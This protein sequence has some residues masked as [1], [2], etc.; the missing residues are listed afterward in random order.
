MLMVGDRFR[1]IQRPLRRILRGAWAWTFNSK[2]ETDVEGE[3]EEYDFVLE[4]TG[5]MMDDGMRVLV[6]GWVG[7]R[8]GKGTWKG[9]GEVGCA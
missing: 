7:M 2:G 4:L 1:S 9:T 3:V 8:N 5:W 6:G